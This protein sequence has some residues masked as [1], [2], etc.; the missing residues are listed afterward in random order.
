MT[1][2]VATVRPA[3]AKEWHP[4]RNGT[5]SPEQVV[6]G[7][8]K[9]VWWQCSINPLHEWPAKVADRVR[10][11][12]CPSCG[13][14]WT[15]ERIRV[16]VQAIQQHIETFT[17]AELYLLFQ[18][19]G[20]LAPK[21]GYR[22][23]IRALATGRFPQREFEKFAQKE[24]SLVDVFFNDPHYTLEAYEQAG[25]ESCENELPAN[26]YPEMHDDRHPLALDSQAFPLVEASDVLGALSSRVISSA[27][28]EAVEF[29]TTSVVAKLWKH[30][31]HDA[32][33][34]VSQARAFHGDTYAETVAQ[35]FLLEY[36]AAQSLAIPEGYAFQ[37]NS[38]RAL[39]NLMQRLVVVRLLQQKRI[40]NWSGTGAGKTLSA[41]LASR[42]IHAHFTLICCPNSVVDEWASSIRAVFPDSIVATKTLTPNWS[43]LYE[44][45]PERGERTT[46]PRYLIVN[47][48]AFQQP[49]SAATVQILLDDES[50]DFIVID[51]IHYTKQRRAEDMSRRRQLVMALVSEAGKKNA[52]LHILALS[53]TPFINNLQ[54]GKSMV[55][56][57]TGLAHDEIE[58]TATVANCM[59]LHQKLVQLGIRWMPE[60]DLEYDQLEIPVDCSTYLDDIRALRNV[61]SVLQLEQ[62][63]TRA[64]LPAIR[65]HIRPKTLIYSHLIQGIDR[66]LYESLTQDG[67]RVGFYTG[68]EKSGLKQ[69][70]DG[71]L[72]VLIGSSAIG[73]G[74]DRLQHV[75]NNLI[76]NVLP[77]THAEFEQLKGRLYRQGQAQHK[78]TM[79][80]PLTSAEV[81]GERWSWCESKMQRLHFKKSVADAAVDGVVP[82]GHLRTPAEAYQDV[83]RWLDRLEAGNVIEVSR[84]PVHIPLS[85]SEHEPDA[86]HAR[87]GDFSSMN[88]LWNQ[89]RS[90]T[91]HTRLAAYPE[92]W[93]A[94]HAR[95]RVARKEWTVVPCEEMLQWIKKR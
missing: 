14:G 9:L 16:F 82:E 87:Y 68:E 69:F 23:F 44:E 13:H 60:Y 58:I 21:A 2:C 88:R 72:D 83:M 73:T 50:F 7:S 67:W 59:S 84:T 57:V 28:E 74:I 62:I 30:A 54:E 1:N 53:A 39:P 64:R 5:L 70:I 42:V 41:I 94:Y 24:P 66:L 15:L 12:G 38:Q 48:E 51:E 17:A 31:F 81:N 32:E 35:R 27:D 85:V 8:E 61:G 71:D 79:V 29:L 49:T 4:T 26:I 43:T 47:Y 36:D 11:T 55:E 3:L 77:W 40:D 76:I 52:D 63:L 19:N 34:A 93:A 22:S 46:K 80:I 45:I 20:L 86:K 65:E 90:E 18:P 37:V 10:G 33:A 91:T 92:E 75:C 6:A 78:V 56:L 89:A 95:Y 25:E